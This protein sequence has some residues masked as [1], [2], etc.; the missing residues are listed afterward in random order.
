MI[1]I[2]LF[3]IIVVVFSKN[4]A[5]QTQ[6][7]TWEKDSINNYLMF[8]YIASCECY[9]YGVDTHESR[10][11][12]IN[13]KVVKLNKSDSIA[14][15]DAIIYEDEIYKTFSWGPFYIYEANIKNDTL[16]LDNE[17]GTFT[18]NNESKSNKEPINFSIPINKGQKLFIVDK[19]K[20]LPIEI[21]LNELLQLVE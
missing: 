1:R 12:F 2:F 9:L 5:A 8:Y 16:F 13:Y 6:K 19:N 21:N 11:L 18:V 17:I 3:T 10:A 20:M 7:Y 14:S 4:T 15:I